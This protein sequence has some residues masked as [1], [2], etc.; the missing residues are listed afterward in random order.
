MKKPIKVYENGKRKAIIR[1]SSGIVS[2]PYAVDF[3]YDGYP[4]YEWK[5]GSH[6]V[7]VELCSTLK[8]ARSKARSYINRYA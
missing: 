2:E 3:L 7:A 4:D 5:K 8:Q 1:E 6:V